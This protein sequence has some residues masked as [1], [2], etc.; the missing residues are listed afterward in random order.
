[1]ISAISASTGGMLAAERR[2]D[3]SASRV[4]MLGSDTPEARTVDPAAE[5]VAM[6]T[7]RLDFEANASVLRVSTGMVKRVLDIRV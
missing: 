4:A 6:A 3:A 2:L 5:I 1:M 7:A